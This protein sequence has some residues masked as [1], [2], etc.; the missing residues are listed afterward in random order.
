MDANARSTRVNVFS[1]G[2][3]DDK[4]GEELSRQLVWLRIP[5]SQVRR[6]PQRGQ[7]R[8][9]TGAEGRTAQRAIGLQSKCGTRET[10]RKRGCAHWG[11]P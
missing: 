8:Q 2:V 10:M 4:H 9:R 11:G 3:S 7:S 5:L 6:M 1:A